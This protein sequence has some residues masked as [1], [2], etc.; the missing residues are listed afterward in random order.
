MSCKLPNLVP[1]PH[2]K[3]YVAVKISR[4]TNLYNEKKPLK[5]EKI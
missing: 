2:L 3:T 4:I 1:S 5:E